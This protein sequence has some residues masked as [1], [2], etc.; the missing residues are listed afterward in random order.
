LYREGLA[1]LIGR[2]DHVSVAW[3]ARTLAVAMRSMALV[4]V[5]LVLLSLDPIDGVDGLDALRTLRGHYPEVRVL[6][7]G[8]IVDREMA[9]AVHKSGAVGAF[10]RD[11]GVTEFLNAVRQALAGSVVAPLVP[12]MRS[13]DLVPPL[14]SPSRMARSALSVREMQVLQEIRQGMTN[15]EISVRLGISV[16]TV[17]KHVQTVLGKLGARNRAHA[18]MIS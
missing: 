2:L 3:S 8:A 14:L 6:G 16:S 15:R 9:R 12:R 5:S 10:E 18:A 11:I 4:P 13:T 17:N 7:F 1:S